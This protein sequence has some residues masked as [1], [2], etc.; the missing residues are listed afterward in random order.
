MNK[1][2]GTAMAHQAALFSFPNT[3]YPTRV[4]LAHD[5]S[6]DFVM[7]QARTDG[8]GCDIVLINRLDAINMAHAILANAGQEAA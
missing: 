7:V 8:N 2:L 1:H 6:G 5:G 4:E 3:T